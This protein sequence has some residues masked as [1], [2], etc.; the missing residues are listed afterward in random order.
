[1]NKA[2]FFLVLLIVS[3]PFASVKANP[4]GWVSP[5]GHAG[6]DV[7][8]VAP[9]QAYDDNEATAT[10]WGWGSSPCTYTGYLYLTHDAL[11]SDKIRFKASSTQSDLVRIDI[12]YEGGGDDMIY[13]GGITGAW[14]EVEFEEASVIKMRFRFHVINAFWGS[15][16]P[17]LTEAD[18][19]E[20][21]AGQDLTF[22][23]YETMSFS[24]SSFM[25]K[26]KAFQFNETVTCMHASFIWKEKIFS[27][28]ETVSGYPYASMNKEL[29]LAF[30]ESIQATS[31]LFA[32][33]KLNIPVLFVGACI[34][35]GLIGFVLYLSRKKKG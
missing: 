24:S 5:T 35:L 31:K 25:W 32:P 26:E 14:Q 19:W 23:F 22:S 9:H 17:S 33:S 30:L 16:M 27:F 20:I 29:L 18:F 15:S 2:Y 34:V 11:T 6:T 1:M 10:A 3:I 21:E 13:F 8:W 12:F 7:S 28:A 4:D